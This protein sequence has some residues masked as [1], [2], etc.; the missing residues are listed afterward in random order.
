MKTPGL[1][2]FSCRAMAVGENA[3]RLA[4]MPYQKE[5]AGLLSP[6]CAKNIRRHLEKYRMVGTSIQVGPPEYIF[7]SVTAELS[8]RPQYRDGGRMAR[9]RIR[10]FFEARKERMGEP[11]KY[12]Q[13]YAMLDGLD[14]VEEIRFL[15]LEARG[16][17]F[18]R[19]G[20]GDVIPPPDGVFLLKELE[21][22]TAV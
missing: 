4:V 18:I 12:R 20:S 7:V 6:A 21:C 14:F 3:V 2:L 15:T 10:E 19:S 8:I 17:R 11:L 13:L 1:R 9:E 5:G 16:N 22:I